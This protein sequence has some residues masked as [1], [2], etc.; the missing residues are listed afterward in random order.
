MLHGFPTFVAGS[1][2]ALLRMSCAVVAGKSRA[3]LIGRRQLYGSVKYLVNNIAD[4][5]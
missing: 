4:D 3:A 2:P 5:P 1:A